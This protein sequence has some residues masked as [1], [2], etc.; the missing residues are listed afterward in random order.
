[1]SVPYLEKGFGD[2]TSDAVTTGSRD[3][4][5]AEPS[6]VLHD[7]STLFLDPKTAETKV[8]EVLAQ[9]SR[10]TEVQDVYQCTPLQEGLVALSMR[11]PG[12]FMPQITFL[13]PSSSPKLFPISIA[14][15]NQL[16][17]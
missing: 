6:R 15:T 8:Q 11:Q 13:H 1:M 12:K 2:S 5:M 9:F 16:L 17:V 10:S 3:H 7:S 14:C 4:D